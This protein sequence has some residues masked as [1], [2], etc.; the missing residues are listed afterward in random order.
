MLNSTD[1]EIKVKPSETRD[2]YNMGEVD[3][4]VFNMSS[5]DLTWTVHDLNNDTLSI[6]LNFTDP[7]EIS[8]DEGKQDILIV[9]FLN[10]SKFMTIKNE[11]VT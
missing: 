1:L 2:I 3:T 7:Y 11:N 8:S 4:S 5:L 10:Q 9:K 6:H